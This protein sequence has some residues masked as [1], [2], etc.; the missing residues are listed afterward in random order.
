VLGDNMPEACS[1][2][3]ERYQ[4]AQSAYQESGCANS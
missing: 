1:T 3:A 2:V 4:A